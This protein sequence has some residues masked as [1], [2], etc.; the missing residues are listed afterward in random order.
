[1]TP[2]H[3]DDTLLAAYAEGRLDA[4][5]SASIE[6]HLTGCTRCRAVLAPHADADLLARAWADTVDTLDRPRVTVFE[7]A[8]T[9]LGLPAPAA[10]LAVG[11]SAA[12]RAWVLGC[13]LVAAF[14]IVARDAEGRTAAMFLTAAPLVPLTGVA[15]AYGRGSF[16]MHDV[17]AA[18]PYP[19]LRLVL[20]RCLPVLPMTALLLVVGGLVLP[21]ATEAALWLL[22]GLALA[23]LG[24]AIERLVGVG[25]SVGGLATVWIAFVGSA[26]VTTGSAR[27]AFSPTVQLLSLVIVLATAAVVVVAQ[28]RTRRSS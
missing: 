4:A 10:R 15:L 24:L 28:H 6:Q 8:L 3:A 26:R 11:A 27:N 12:R 23:A 1:M 21:E 17:V 22:P 18:V 2:W 19:R 7:R 20:L 16:P 14:A 13:V 25:A 9:G 5:R